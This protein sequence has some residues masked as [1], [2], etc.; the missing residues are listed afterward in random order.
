MTNV[1]TETLSNW[2]R[3]KCLG[4]KILILIFWIHSNK[5]FTSKRISPNQANNS[6]H[7]WYWRNPNILLHSSHVIEP[8]CSVI[9]RFRKGSRSDLKNYV[10][11]SWI[12]LRTCLDLKEFYYT[13]D[14]SKNLRI[15]LELATSKPLWVIQISTL[16]GHKMT[17]NIPKRV[18]I[19]FYFVTA[20]QRA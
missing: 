11:E 16:Y 5:I 7:N 20:F 9:T 4:S 6:F 1:I 12:E 19:V 17:S 2:V 15:Q 8:I 14:V 18:L 13:Q 10:V 3:P